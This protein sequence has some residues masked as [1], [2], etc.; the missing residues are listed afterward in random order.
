[1][2]QCVCKADPYCCETRW[3]LSCVGLVGELGCGAACEAPIACGE[4]PAN[5]LCAQAIQLSK[6]G[7]VEGKTG[8]VGSSGSLCGGHLAPE[9][10]Y[11]YTV[12]S[13]AL[14]DIQVTTSYAEKAG[15]EPALRP[16]IYLRDGCGVGA[17]E[18]LCGEYTLKTDKLGPGTYYLAVDGRNGDAG[19]FTLEVKESTPCAGDVDCQGVPAAPACDQERGRCVRCTS[20]VHCTSPFAP[21]CDSSAQQCVSC[22]V[23]AHCKDPTKPRCD[24]GKNACVACL[25]GADCKAP[26]SPFCN[27][28]NKSCSACLED[29]DC[30]DPLKPACNL[31]TG[32]CAKQGNCCEATS[33]IAGCVDDTIEA[34]VCAKDSF[35]CETSWDNLCAGEVESFGCGLCGPACAKAED[36][37]DPAR[38]VCVP[39]VGKCAGCAGDANCK[40][41][42]T[43]VCK[44]GAFRCVECTDDGDCGGEPGKPR[45]SVGSGACVACVQDA[46]CGGD[47]PFCSAAGGCV[48]C[49][50]DDDCGGSGLPACD[51]ST[52]TCV[53]CLS[54]FYCTD[55]AKPACDATKNVCV[56]QGDCCEVTP[57]IPGCS[58][59][60]IES[61][62]CVN[63]PQCCTEQW[64]AECAAL[65]EQ[66][67]CSVCGPACKADGDCKD[68]ARPA[69]VP[70]VEKCA[71]CSDD[72]DCKAPNKP[73][74]NPGVFQCVRACCAVTAAPGCAVDDTIEACVCAKDSFCCE[75]SWDSLCAAEVVKF[76]CG[77]CP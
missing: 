18:I 41:P 20:D 36:C 47:T 54:D 68:P 74:C 31:P 13:P 8:G 27:T 60:P 24:S 75:T 49:R 70:G 5:G 14:L 21:A 11:S 76:G 16:V 56:K 23:D 33:Q 45:C 22:V 64:S 66:L 1:M 32:S 63:A 10:W 4:A 58:S 38:P 39:S 34:C 15:C 53:P 72:S 43:P 73:S 55:P 46:D 57:D 35:C 26:G 52:R 44:P 29:K 12:I 25:S 77:A 40:D 19:D 69:C 42:A 59:P 6:D 61:C 71:A 9:V 37:V 51:P 50:D 48:A 62:V 2:E 7:V 17:K 30:P 67:G 65:V 28:N 3:D